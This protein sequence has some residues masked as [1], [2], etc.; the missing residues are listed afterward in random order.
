MAPRARVQTV[1]VEGNGLSSREVEKI[2]LATIV[3][4]RENWTV[5]DFAKNLGVRDYGFD[6]LKDLGADVGIDNDAFVAFFG[7]RGD[8]GWKLDSKYL[9]EDDIS[10]CRRQS[11][12]V[13][14]HLPSNGYYLATFLREYQGLQSF[15]ELKITSYPTQTTTVRRWA[16]FVNQITSANANLWSLGSHALKGMAHTHKRIECSIHPHFLSMTSISVSFNV[17]TLTP[18]QTSP[19]LQRLTPKLS[20]HNMIQLTT[21]DANIAAKS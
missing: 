21:I 5:D 19:R 20:L 10:H 15:T 9:S 1:K 6:T 12:L 13:Y 17:A 7:P 8:Q 3:L 18:Y 14:G 4:E 2:R 16:P 11:A